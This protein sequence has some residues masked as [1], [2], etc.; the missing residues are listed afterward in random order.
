M[1][2]DLSRA[3]AGHA[4]VS[5]DDLAAHARRHGAVDCNPGLV[6]PDLA[7]DEAMLAD[8]LEA[9]GVPVVPSRAVRNRALTSALRR[10]RR[11]P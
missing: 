4:A 11:M 1:T 10:L 3:L 5:L 9:M 8:T 2:P 7:D 6:P